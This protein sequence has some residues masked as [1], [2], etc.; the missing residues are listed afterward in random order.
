MLIWTLHVKINLV[1]LLAQDTKLIAMLAGS[2]TMSS[3]AKKTCNVCPVPVTPPCN[4]ADT[5]PTHICE[6]NMAS[7]NATAVHD[8][9]FMEKS[10]A[11]SCGHCY[12]PEVRHYDF[13]GM[14]EDCGPHILN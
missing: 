7:C 11:K 10:C 9:K 6:A 3:I 13:Y 2:K 8:Y 14:Y 12:Q 1:T 4:A 5:A